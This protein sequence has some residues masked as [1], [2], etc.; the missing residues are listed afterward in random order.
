[1]KHLRSAITLVALAAPAALAEPVS[2]NEPQRPTTEPP[3]PTPPP[4]CPPEPSAADVASAPIPGDEHGRSD[5]VDSGDSPVRVIARGLLWLPKLVVDTALTPVRGTVWAFERYKLTDLYYDTFF[6]DARTIGLYPTLV[7]ESGFG[8]TGLTGGARFVDRDLFGEREHLAIQ[9]ALGTAYYRQLVSASLRSGNRFGKRFSLELDAGY[10]KRPRDPF[11]GIGNGNLAPPPDMLIDPRVDSTAVATRYRQQ[12]ER[13]ALTSDAR[14]VSDLHLRAN[15]AV[16]RLAFSSANP[17]DGTPIDTVYDPAALGGFE[18][19]VEYGYGELE[20]R[21]D[22]RHAA[23]P[24]ESAGVFSTGSLASAFT[25][26][27]HRL[28]GDGRDFYRYGFDLQ[29]FIRIAA[30]PRVF[31][32][33]L[34]GEAVSGSYADV[35]FSELPKLGGPVYLRGYDLDRFRDRVAM[36]GSAEYQ[37]D[38]SAWFAAKLF[39]DAGRV[40]PSVNE[41]AFDHL[42]LGYG[43]G[44]E[45]HTEHAFVLD[46]S[47][48]S[49]I[50]GGLFFNVAFNPVFDLDERVRRR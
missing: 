24:L 49:S 23:N 29:N 36:F 11:Y 4:A 14:V 9:G 6:N 28:D 38:L 34:H 27:M 22:G 12:R 2:S 1:M 45:A 48:A 25:G 20:L 13:V 47:L 21:W 43:G 35:P 19:G 39:V 5:G 32:T 30:G 17:S 37:W 44:I 33:R 8:I 7:F 3:P 31:A 46:M 18:S 26:R 42:R 41:L 10:E 40:Y 50:D 15:G 16:S